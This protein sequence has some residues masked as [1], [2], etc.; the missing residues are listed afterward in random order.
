LRDPATDASRVQNP[1][2][3]VIVGI[4]THPGCVP[5]GHQ[6]PYDGWFCPCHGSIYTSSGRIRQ[7]PAAYNLPVQSYKFSFANKITIG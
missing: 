7:E 3:L 5:V 6:G 1:E 4:C 2:W